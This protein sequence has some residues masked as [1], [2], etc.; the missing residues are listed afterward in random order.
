L[1]CC[2]VRAL[3]LLSSIDHDIENQHLDVFQA[4]SNCI[5]R[6]AAAAAGCRFRKKW[7]KLLFR[8]DFSL[9][10]L[11]APAGVHIREGFCRQPFP[12]RHTSDEIAGL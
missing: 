6:K 1:L 11:N 10:A 3:F 9:S 12:F 8:C 7:K 2:F 4:F 5:S